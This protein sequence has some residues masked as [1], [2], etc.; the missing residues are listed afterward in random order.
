[1]GEWMGERA[2]EWM[3]A[4]VG[5]QRA[6]TEPSLARDIKRC[7]PRRII[8]TK[9]RRYGSPGSSPAGRGRV[10]RAA[11]NSLAELGNDSAP[12]T[13]A[14]PAAT[15]FARSGTH[16]ED[17]II[18]DDPLFQMKSPFD[19][20]WKQSSGIRFCDGRNASPDI[21]VVAS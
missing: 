7:N 3:G 5:E 10:V 2:G 9:A 18:G 11:R 14:A 12:R 15:T 19:D 17:P 4:R 16:T 13:R 1:M 21:F 20:R 6:Y 8:L